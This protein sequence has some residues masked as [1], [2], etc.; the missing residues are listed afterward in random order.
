[1]LVRGDGIIYATGLTFTYTPE[2][3]APPSSSS[4]RSQHTDNILYH[5]PAAAGL[6]PPPAHIAN[7]GST[8]YSILTASDRFVDVS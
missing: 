8:S 5:K 4:R 2:P 1:M 3:G 7:G 6:P